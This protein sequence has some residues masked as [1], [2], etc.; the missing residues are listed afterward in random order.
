MG[1]LD[2]QKTDDL[3][4][5]IAINKEQL[6]MMWKSKPVVINLYYQYNHFF[7]S[8]VRWTTKDDRIGQ[9]PTT[10]SIRALSN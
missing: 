9:T 10:R 2:S 6:I 7:S 8:R 3:A 5:K 4:I 1:D